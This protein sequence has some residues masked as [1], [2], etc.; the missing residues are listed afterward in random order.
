MCASIAFA[1]GYAFYLPQSA[2]T[3]FISALFFVGVGGGNFAIYLIWIPEQYRSESRGS[4]FALATCVGRF[5]AAATTFVVGAGVSSYGS[6]GVPV[7]LTAV[8][9]AAGLF[10]IP[11][12]IE[13]R[14]QPLPA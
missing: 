13:T 1:F 2:L 11:F 14:G 10:V 8:V 9:F 12:S 7:A 5:V 6:I 3:I 4:A